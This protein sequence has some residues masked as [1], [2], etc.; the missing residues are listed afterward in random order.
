MNI[1]RVFSRLTQSPRPV[2]QEYRS[3]FTH[4]YFD[5]GWWGVLNGTILSFLS[6]YATRLG[7]NEREIGFLSAAPAFITMIMALPAGV[8]LMNKRID[9]AVFWTSIVFRSFYLLIAFLPLVFKNMPVE[10]V[11]MIIGITLVMSV[12]GTALQ[13]GFNSLFGAAVPVEWRG[14]VAGIRNATF[15]IATTATTL[16]VGQI[17]NRVAFPENF[18]IVFFIGVAGGFMSSLHLY[19]VKP[20]EATTSTPFGGDSNLSA[21]NGG[22][23]A[24]SALQRIRSGVQTRFRTDILHGPFGKVLLLMGFFHLAWYM[25]SPVFP[26]FQ[27]NE[28]GLTDRNISLG[29]ALFYSAVFFGSTRLASITARKGNRWTTGMGMVFLSSYPLLLPFCTSLGMFLFTS[30]LGGAAFSLVNGALYNYLL[31]EVPPADR[32]SHLA[33]FNLVANLAVLLASLTGPLIA[34]WIGLVPAL[35]LFGFFRMLGGA[36]ILRFG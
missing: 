28:I 35:F 17:L 18:Q 24:K 32:P 25:P 23:M 8:W 4:L 27:V 5:I 13:V 15:A 36:T 26:V 14:T 7:A 6:I 34:G 9:R 10:Q 11:W 19:F 31:D 16:V 20:L 22:L 12:P 21:V 33:W 3:N 29:S 1:A 2:P 30:F